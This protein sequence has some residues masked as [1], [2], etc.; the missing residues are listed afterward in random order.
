MSGEND[1]RRTRIK[2]PRQRVAK[3]PIAEVVLAARG[4]EEAGR[5]GGAERMGELAPAAKNPGGREKRGTQGGLVG[6]GETRE[7]AP[8]VKDPGRE[9]Q[10]ENQC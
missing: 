6:V 4:P 7:P 10:R 8:A 3:K 2:G 9:G 5:P 1:T